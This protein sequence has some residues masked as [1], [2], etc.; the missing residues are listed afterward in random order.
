MALF[1][2]CISKI[3]NIE[4]D[5]AQHIDIVML[6]YNL[7]EYSDDFSKTSGSLQQCC[8][9]IAAVDDSGA[10]VGFNGTNA[11]DSFNFKTKITNKTA[12]N[13]DNGKIA[14]RVDVEITVPLKYLRNFWRTLEISLINYEIELILICQQ[15]VL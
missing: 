9:D 12:D 10:I 5:N 6:M 15:T 11:T 2:N 1:T 4:I 14:G 13:N 8:K 7:I 3:G